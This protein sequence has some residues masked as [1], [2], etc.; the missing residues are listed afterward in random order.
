MSGNL[1]EGCNTSSLNTF[2][3][4]GLDANSLHGEISFFFLISKRIVMLCLK[5]Q[6][7]A[8][9]YLRL[10]KRLNLLKI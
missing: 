9:A 8:T 6:S 7:Y 3:G 2:T 4:H 1:F 10:R 5:S